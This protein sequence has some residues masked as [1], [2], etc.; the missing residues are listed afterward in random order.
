MSDSPMP[1]KDGGQMEFEIKEAEMY[2]IYSFMC[3]KAVNIKDDKN[4]EYCEEFRDEYGVYDRKEGYSFAYKKRISRQLILNMPYNHIKDKDN[5]KI[6]LKDKDNIRNFLNIDK[7]TTTIPFEECTL[8]IYEDGKGI[9]RFK[10]RL[11]LK[12]KPSIK[13]IVRFMD[14]CSLPEM[15]KLVKDR[16]YHHVVSERKLKLIEDEMGIVP[17][18]DGFIW[19]IPQILLHLKLDNYEEF[20]NANCD[21]RLKWIH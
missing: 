20:V 3:D 15:W 8:K 16:I 21:D 14:L 5:L 6:D 2:F 13:D 10:T 19:Q 18:E 17:K 11:K 9:L 7:D 4:K 1:N 12:E